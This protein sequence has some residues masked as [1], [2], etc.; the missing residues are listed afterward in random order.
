MLGAD[1]LQLIAGVGFR[2]GRGAFPPSAETR[3]W[4]IAIRVPC[5]RP[6]CGPID[7]KLGLR[8]CPRSTGSSFPDPCSGRDVGSC[9]PHSVRHSIEPHLC[10][11]GL[12][13]S[14]SPSHSLRLPSSTEALKERPERDLVRLHRGKATLPSDL[15]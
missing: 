1:L 6:S 12:R 4:K 3:G 2:R 11:P 13:I 10:S 15:I 9:W 8:L 7:P 5:V 14:K